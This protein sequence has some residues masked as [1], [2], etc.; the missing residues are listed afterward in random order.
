[1]LR[2]RD[3]GFGD[4]PALVDIENGIFQYDVISP[5]QMRYLLRSDT[6]MVMKAEQ[7]N[8]IVGYMVLLRRRN[9]TALRIYSL[10]V[11]QEARQLGIGNQL[12][13][14]AE[15]QTTRVGC[16]RLSLE[17]HMQNRGALIFYLAAGF[18]IYGRKTDY[19]TDGSSALL[20]RKYVASGEMI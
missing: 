10:G 2:I 7:G 20:L 16:N 17:L 3:A 12:L 15:L 1:M 9:C 11:V 14:W 8:A 19:Y 13:L 18:C 5:R 4:L 6:A